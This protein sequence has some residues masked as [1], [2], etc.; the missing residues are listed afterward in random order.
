VCIA[1]VFGLTLSFEGS[2]LSHSLAVHTGAR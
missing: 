1:L 2:I